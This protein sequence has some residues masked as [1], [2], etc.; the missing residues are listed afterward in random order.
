MHTNAHRRTPTNTDAHRRT[1]TNTDDDR[2][3]SDRHNGRNVATQ[4]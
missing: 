3:D 1:P 4:R 2:R